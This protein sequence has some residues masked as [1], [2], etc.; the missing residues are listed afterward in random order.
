MILSKPK[1]ILRLYNETLKNGLVVLENEDISKIIEDCEKQG[2]YLF[3]SESGSVWS[4]VK[5]E[6]KKQPCIRMIFA[7]KENNGGKVQNI[8]RVVDLIKNTENTLLYVDFIDIIKN[9][10]F[11]YLNIVKII[12]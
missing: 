3:N 12:R 9:E 8:D 11:I 6:W 2:K 4:F 10:K 1:A 5:S 7:I